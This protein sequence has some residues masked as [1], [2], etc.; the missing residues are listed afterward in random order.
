MSF[1]IYPAID[2]RAGGVVRLCQGDYAQETR[3]PDSPLDLAQK[4]ARQGA[5]WLHLVDLDAARSGGYGL[6]ELV[7]GIKATTKLEVQTGGGV[8][9]QSDIEAILDAGAD[10]V[11]IGS[12]AIREPALAGAWL[13]AF[14]PER[15]VFALDVKQNPQGRWIL[16]SHGW[17]E[18]S[19]VAFDELLARHAGS[20][21]RHLLCTDIARDGMLG[22]LNVSLYE[23]LLDFA[24]GLQLQASGGVRGVADV[25]V[26]RAAGCA[27]VV[28]GKALLEG[29]CALGEALLE[30]ASC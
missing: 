7:A 22:G 19:N 27:G 1:T 6:A 29:G 28:V 15:L 8:R 14:G 10:R 9:R 16:P 2:V 4:Y 11:V 20:G 5:Q 21:L 12:A 24:P 23:W 25:L 30:T 13:Q 18:A 3:Y 17:T 26:A